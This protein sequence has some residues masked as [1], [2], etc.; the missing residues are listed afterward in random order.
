MGTGFVLVFL[1]VFGAVG[2][3]MLGYGVWAARRSMQAGGWPMVTGRLLSVELG[4]HT[5]SDGDELWEVKPTYAYTVDGKE[6]SG[7][8]LAFG[9]TGSGGK[10]VHEE[11]CQ[12]LKAAN[13]IDVR[14]DPVN[15]ATAVL[16]YGV[17]RSIR[18]IL[19]F[20]VTWLA[21]VL[22]IAACWW[23]ARSGDHV[24]LHNL[25]AR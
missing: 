10:A 14:Y 25:S 1:G 11:I 6:Y 15:P 17:H 7:S 20:A 21:F 2:V 13:S 3:G 23:V 12:R 8:R 19:A 9:Y 4:A 5:D 16:S 18:F 22:G 24:L